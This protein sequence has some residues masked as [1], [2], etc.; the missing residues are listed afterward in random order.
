LRALSTRSVEALRGRKRHPTIEDDVTI[1]G[2]AIILGGATT[3]GQGAT[4]GGAVFLTTSV[5]PG[6]SVSVKD[7]QLKMTDH[8]KR[9]K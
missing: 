7:P 6:Y 3:I 8:S 1:Y 9:K 5:P 4:I 2:G